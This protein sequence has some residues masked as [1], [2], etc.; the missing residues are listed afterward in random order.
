MNNG[1]ANQAMRCF[2]VMIEAF[3]ERVAAFNPELECELVTVEPRNKHELPPSGCDLFLSSGGP[4]GPAD[5]DGEAWLVEYRKLLDSIVEGHLQG[6]ALAP[7]MFG[8]CYT[9]ELLIRHFEVAQMQLR[10][11]RKFGV[12]PVYMT[13]A[14]MQHA[15]TARFHDR[16]FAFEHRNWEAV[17]LEERKLDQLGG[18]VL[19]RESRDGVSKGQALLGLDF[20][21][22]IEGT[23]FHPEADKSG[24]VAWLAKREQ[25]EAFVAAYGKVTYEKMLQTLDNPDRIAKTFTLL[26]PGWL[27]RKFNEQADER[28]WR[29]LPPPVVDIE[30]FSGESPPAVS[31]AHPSLLPP[32]PAR[33]GKPG[34]VPKLLAASMCFD[35]AAGPIDPSFLR[36]L[37]REL[38]PAV[39]DDGA[40][41]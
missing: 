32:P 25:A 28:G 13:Q 40:Q 29:R 14:G 38:D 20:A 24:V 16:L 26:I 35:D 21:P 5:H 8:V 4:G 30:L 18:K 37:E 27:T 22:G 23:Q 1:H 31:V 9:F 17:D 12:M 15:L 34:S 19:A 39:A 7:S 36:P 2:A 10:A 41:A 33:A 11:T 3:F 6:R